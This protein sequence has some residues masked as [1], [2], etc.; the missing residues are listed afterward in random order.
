MTL[1][2]IAGTSGLSVITNGVDEKQ[3]K[4][5]VPPSTFLSALPKKDETMVEAQ[6]PP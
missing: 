6:L 1:I 3:L 4:L 5:R 2:F